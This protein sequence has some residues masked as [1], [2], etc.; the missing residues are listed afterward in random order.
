MPHDRFSNENKGTDLVEMH[1][2][3]GRESA[4]VACAPDGPVENSDYY[5]THEIRSRR[6]EPEKERERERR[7]WADKRMVCRALMA[8]IQLAMQ[9]TTTYR[10]SDSHAQRKPQTS[11]RVATQLE[12]KLLVAR[13]ANTEF[14]AVWHQPFTARILRPCGIGVR[15]DFIIRIHFSLTFAN[16][17]FSSQ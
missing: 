13:T 3:G 4:D 7:G 17:F 10:G 15:D 11:S 16:L 2:T 6:E 12:C 14:I 1:N 5:E 8:S 9:S